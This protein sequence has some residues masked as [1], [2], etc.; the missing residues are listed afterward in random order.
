GDFRDYQWK[1]T[2]KGFLEFKG[3]RFLMAW[4]FFFG[5]TQS[6]G[7]L[8]LPWI[9]RDR[10]MRFPL[11]AGA[12]FLFC[13]AGETWYWPHYFAPATGLAFLIAIQ[14]MRHVRFWRWHGRA[15]GADLVR[16][17]PLIG[18]ALILI[19]ITGILA[20]APIEP[21]WPRGDLARAALLRKLEGTPGEHLILMHYGPGHAPDREWVYNAADIDHAK[22]VWAH[23]MGEPDN[24]ELLQY[25][26]DRKIWRVDPDA[27][28]LHLQPVPSPSA[29]PV[30]ASDEK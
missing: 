14:G 25:F 18:C 21:A 8:A 16:S 27:T 23:D 1:R 28:P 4:G 7:L 24:R 12:A 10:R 22:V 26:R 13:L 11:I 9:I 2:L 19:R 15:V 3:M 5:A 6:I 30:P 20:H 17:V 29:A